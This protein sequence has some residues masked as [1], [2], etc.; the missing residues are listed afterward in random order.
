VGTCGPHRA[1]EST[2]AGL[3]RMGWFPFKV[4]FGPFRAGTSFAP[5][6]VGCT[7]GYSRSAPSGQASVGLTLAREVTSDNKMRVRFRACCRFLRGQLAGRCKVYPS[8]AVYNL[9][10]MERARIR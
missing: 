5:L 2:P 8:F 3:T 9:P 7:H 4:L 10:R 1:T 6:P